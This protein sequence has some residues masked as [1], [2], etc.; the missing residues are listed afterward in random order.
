MCLRSLETIALSLPRP[1]MQ[2]VDVEPV[3]E[4]NEDDE[5]DFNEANI[6]RFERT[7]FW[8][9][10]HRDVWKENTFGRDQLCEA[11]GINR[12]L[13]LQSVRSQ[14][15]NN[16]HD[17]INAYRVKEL[18]RMITAG[19]ARTL[20]ECLE[21]GFGTIKTARSSYEKV[22]NESLDDSLARYKA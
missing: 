8:M 4:E 6:R 1:E 5:E 13:L 9:Q 20:S 2:V 21:A 16:I 10:H 17:Y 22:T 15:H 19:E 14:G 11:T 12:H 7:E 3:L 18:Q